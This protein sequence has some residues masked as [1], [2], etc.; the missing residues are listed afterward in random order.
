MLDPSPQSSPLVMKRFVNC[1]HCEALASGT[2]RPARRRYAT[3]SSA[4]GTIGRTSLGCCSGNQCNLP[5][6]H[7]IIYV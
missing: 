6:Y 1:R 5:A 2:A 4:S 3:A 7:D